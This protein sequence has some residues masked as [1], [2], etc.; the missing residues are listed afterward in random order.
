MEG[1]MTLAIENTEYKLGVGDHFDVPAKTP[2]EATI[3]L[4][5]CTYVIGE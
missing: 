4:D 1:Q 3:G 5:G 2:H